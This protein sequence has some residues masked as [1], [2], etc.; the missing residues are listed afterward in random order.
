VTDVQR[1]AWGDRNPSG[2]DGANLLLPAV[3]ALAVACAYVLGTFPSADIAARLAV[4]RH[5]DIRAMGS[6]NPGA[7]N[8]TGQLGKGWGAFVLILDVAKAA[9]ACGLGRW[10]AG[11]AAA[12]AAGTAAVVGHCFPLWNGLRGGKGV[13]CAGGQ[14]LMTAPLLVPIEAVVALLGRR[15][16][17]RMYGLVCAVW[18]A[19]TAVWWIAELPNGWGP[20]PTAGLFLGAL[21]SSAVI[22]SRF[23]TA[24]PLDERASTSP[25]LA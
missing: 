8:V 15:L 6:G 24:T 20:R 2:L 5:A 19:G 12:S 3:I 22:L 9:A 17:S 14:L 10:F 7:V 21:A 18:I 25:K 16:R 4:G 23:A 13:A 1:H 11:D